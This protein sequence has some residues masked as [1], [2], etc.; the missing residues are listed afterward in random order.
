MVLT[1]GGTEEGE[2]AHGARFGLRLLT[3]QALRAEA[4]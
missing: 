4:V 1:G 2:E 3:G